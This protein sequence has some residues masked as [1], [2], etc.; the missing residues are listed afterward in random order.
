MEVREWLNR[1]NLTLEEVMLF[2]GACIYS[3]LEAAVTDMK[4]GF[5]AAF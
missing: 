1:K 3:G 2:G 5:G 4:F